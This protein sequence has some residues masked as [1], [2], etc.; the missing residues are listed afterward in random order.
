MKRKQIEEQYNYIS[1]RLKELEEE[2]EDLKKYQSLDKQRRSLEYALWDNDMKDANNK[3]EEV[4]SKAWPMPYHN[5]VC[6]DGGESTRPATQSERE[7]V[8]DGGSE[9]IIGCQRQHSE[10]GGK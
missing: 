8:E 9:G 4:R 6:A 7:S 3:V 1:D 5:P 2:K 10:R